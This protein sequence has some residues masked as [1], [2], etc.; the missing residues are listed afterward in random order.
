MDMDRNPYLKLMK[1][2]NKTLTKMKYML[3]KDDVWVSKNQVRVH[4]RKKK[5]HGDAKEEQEAS[6][7]DEIEVMSSTWNSGMKNRLIHYKR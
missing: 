2:D 7:D 4:T 1:I 6:S 5:K 3:N